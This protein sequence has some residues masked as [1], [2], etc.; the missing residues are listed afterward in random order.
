MQLADL[1]QKEIAGTL[2]CHEEKELDR[3]M[4]IWYRLTMCGHEVKVNNCLV[5]RVFI[6]VVMLLMIFQIM[7]VVSLDLS[8]GSHQHGKGNN[9]H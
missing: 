7:Y 6:A 9:D 4:G 3:R 8:K 2:S 1:R 5:A